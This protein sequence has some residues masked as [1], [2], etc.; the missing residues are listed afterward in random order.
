M[1]PNCIKKVLDLQNECEKFNDLTVEQLLYAAIVGSDLDEVRRVLN[2][3]DWNK[4]CQGRT[5]RCTF[6]R[7]KTDV[8]AKRTLKG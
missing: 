3:T 6:G 4:W 2:S 7:R 8:C 1:T 5:E